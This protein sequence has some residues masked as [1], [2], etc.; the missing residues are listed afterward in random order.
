[1]FIIQNLNLLYADKN[2]T[3]RYSDT[4]KEY[5]KVYYD[6]YLSVTK[7]IEMFQLFSVWLMTIL[8]LF[9]LLHSLNY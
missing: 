6:R 1:M 7:E 2:D 9:R 8:I 4:F 3:P 5:L